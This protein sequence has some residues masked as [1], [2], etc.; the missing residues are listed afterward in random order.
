MLCCNAVRYWYH[1]WSWGLNNHIVLSQKY[2]STCSEECLR[3]WS[4]WVSSQSIAV[5]PCLRTPS[6]Q[7]RINNHA[8]GFLGLLLDRLNKEFFWIAFSHVSMMNH[9]FFSFRITMLPTHPPSGGITRPVPA[10][11]WYRTKFHQQPLW[12]LARNECDALLGCRLRRLSSSLYFYALDLWGNGW[13][14]LLLI[15]WM[16]I[17]RSLQLPFSR[18]N[19]K[20]ASLRS[21]KSLCPT[22]TSGLVV[23]VGRSDAISSL[24]GDRTLPGHFWVLWF[25]WSFPTVSS[26]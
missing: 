26:S 10:V 9:H 22:D 21:P 8:H 18:A 19:L 24:I 1:V 7:N 23:S 11:L 2:I 5:R 3:C 25:L 6:D 13:S 14:C 4:R 16:R 12:A 17:T 15:S 20:K